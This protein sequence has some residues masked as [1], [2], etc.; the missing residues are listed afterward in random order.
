[1][2]YLP[3]VVEVATRVGKA[4]VAPTLTFV[5]PCFNEQAAIPLLLQKLSDLSERL[6]ATGRIQG[7]ARILLVD[8]GSRDATWQVIQEACE[9]HN[10]TG[11]RLS[12]NHGHQRALLAGLMQA[13][14]DV[15]ISMDADLQDDPDAVPAMLDAYARGSEIVFGVRG[16]RRA[17][18][19]FK[20]RSARAYYDLL[21]WLGVDLVP[22]HADFRLMSRKAISALAG[23]EET[24]LFLRGMIP[25]LG[26]ASETVVY[27]R[28]ARSAG[29]SKYPVGK[30]LAL[31]LEGITSFSIKPL[32]LITLMGALVAGLAFALLFYSLAAWFAGRTITGW[33]STVLPIYLLGGTHMIALGVV[34][35]YIGKIYQE[36]KRRPRFIID[37]TVASAPASPSIAFQNQFAGPGA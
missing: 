17:D 6:A 23:F 34:G 30:M 26:F 33:A 16:A 19:P 4:R 15:V 13:D 14:A 21:S 8:D 31:A 2:S 28:G 9:V 12:R 7:P 32:R 10:L 36:V 35:E 18:T 22:D 25:Q 29:E 11:I 37:E 5:I 1:M 20:R 24:N 27:D 3:R